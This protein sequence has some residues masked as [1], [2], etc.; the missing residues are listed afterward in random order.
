MLSPGQ[1]ETIVNQ[2]ILF[3]DRQTDPADARIEALER[4]VAYLKHNLTALASALVID[5]LDVN[6]GGA[7]VPCKIDMQKFDEMMRNW[8]Q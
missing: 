1:K 3:D 4:E 7:L 6:R 8:K 2:P 5:Q